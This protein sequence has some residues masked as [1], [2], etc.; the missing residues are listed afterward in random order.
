MLSI[1]GASKLKTPGWKLPKCYLPELQEQYETE[2]IKNPWDDIGQ[3]MKLSPYVYQ[4][5]TIHF[6]INNP[7]SLLILP[8]GSGKSPIMI[9]IYL[10]AI[11]N[12]LTNK[13]GIVCVK[14]SLKYQ[15]VKEIEKFSD[16]RAKAI[17]TPS[18]AK[19]KF[20]SQFEDCDLF[21][22]NYET[23]NNADVVKKLREKEVETIMCDEIHYCNSPTAK[24]TK[25]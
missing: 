6:A 3:D 7:K 25:S 9:G 21:V 22:L 15:W 18:K 12:R 20:D 13:P 23:L 16:L 19:K 1:P 11:K 2:F 5:E 8:T 14:A 24:R 10:E 17:E 4:K